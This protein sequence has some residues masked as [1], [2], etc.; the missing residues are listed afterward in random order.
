M[1]QR[2]STFSG[3]TK[4]GA[5]IDNLKHHHYHSAPSSPSRFIARCRASEASSSCENN[6]RLL[7]RYHGDI[8][9]LEPPL[10]VAGNG[11]SSSSSTRQSSSSSSSFLT[12]VWKSTD[13]IFFS[14]RI[15]WLLVFG[16]IAILG[17]S[18]G[19]L[20]EHWSF[21]LAGLALIP[22]AERYVLITLPVYQP[23]Y[24]FSYFVTCMIL[25]LRSIQTV[26]YN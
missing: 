17:K 20:T 1:L 26:F 19:F 12:E 11:L 7:T 14:S 21:L 15:T 10:V 4:Q 3:E 25:T 6:P 24:S 13:H 2:N 9:S 16:P 22:C 8:T 5:R 18:S 23:N